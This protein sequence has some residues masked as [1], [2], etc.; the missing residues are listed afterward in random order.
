MQALTHSE[1]EPDSFVNNMTKVGYKTMKT[2]G[3]VLEH[4]G[5]LIATGVKTVKDLHN[6]QASVTNSYAQNIP[7]FG[8]MVQAV[9]SAIGGVLEALQLGAKFGF[10][11]GGRT[12]VQAAETSKMALRTKKLKE[13]EENIQKAN[14][15]TQT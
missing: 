13:N 14:S 3:N 1:K 4:S 7:Y 11:S 12:V 9:N 6:T 10:R 2:V 8:T 5:D 15:N